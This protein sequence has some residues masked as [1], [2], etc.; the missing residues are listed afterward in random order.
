MFSYIKELINKIKYRNREII[1]RRT[2]R[3]HRGSVLEGLHYFGKGSCFRGF[4]GRGSYI[5]QN[6]GLE[7]WVGR[8]TS[9]APEVTSNPGVHPFKAPFVT[10]SPMFYSAKDLK[11]MTY[12]DFDTFSGNRFADKQHGHVVIIGNDVWIGQRAFLCGGVHIGDGAVVLAGAVVT[13]NVE[14]Y[15]I[16][17]GVP[18]KVI[19]YRFDTETIEFLKEI[20]WWNFPEEW[21]KENWLLLNDIEKLKAY[22]GIR[23]LA[24]KYNQDVENNRID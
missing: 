20:K 21:L 11:G 8:Y 7:A 19:G 15:A 12:A 13:K 17:G 22:P 1:V 3:I 2:A 24:K 4:L 5:G 14:P 18:A 10:Q 9:I 23:E 6:T 16:V